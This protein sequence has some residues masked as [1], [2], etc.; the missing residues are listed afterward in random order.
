MLSLINA[1]LLTIR[2]TISRIYAPRKRVSRGQVFLEYAVIIG[3]V[4]AALVGMQLYLRRMLQG[5]YKSVT[6][7]AV[8]HIAQSNGLAWYPVQ[9]DP[10]YNQSD[11]I[12]NMDSKTTDTRAADGSTSKT[13][14]YDTIAGQGMR[15][16][17]PYSK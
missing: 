10:Y 14:E 2:L 3:V 9:Y 4:V 8:H 15:W 12:T 6:D 1:I 16:E 5:R 17:L 7:Q 11:M 13:V